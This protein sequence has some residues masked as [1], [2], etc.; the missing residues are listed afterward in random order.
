MAPSNLIVS[1]FSILMMTNNHIHNEY[2]D[3]ICKQPIEYN[4]LHKL[5]V[6]VRVSQAAWVGHSFG[7][8]GA[9]LD[10]GNF[11]TVLRLN[12]GTPFLVMTARV[13]CRRVQ[14]QCSSP[15]Y[16]GWQGPWLA[17]SDHASKK[18]SMKPTWKTWLPCQ[19]Q[20]HPNNGTLARRVSRLS[21]LSIKGRHWSRVDHHPSLT[22]W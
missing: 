6:F 11:D 17:K 9:N 16:P 5:C 13:G 1:P 2:W 10:M 12:D 22:R 20:G 19:R 3:R 21:H 7:K 4:A 8:E 14:A 15:G 18:S